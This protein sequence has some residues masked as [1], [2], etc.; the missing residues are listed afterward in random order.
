MTLCRGNTVPVSQ[1]PKVF[2]KVASLKSLFFQT[3]A[4]IFSLRSHTKTKKSSKSSHLRSWNQRMCLHEKGLNNQ[5]S[6]R[7]RQCAVCH[8]FRHL[9]E[10]ADHEVHFN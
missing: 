5:Y 1:F 4:K 6:C 9:R 10:A 2:P 7:L 3:S 8:R